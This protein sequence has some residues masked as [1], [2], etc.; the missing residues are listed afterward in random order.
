[1][2]AVVIV[3]VF[4]GVVVAIIEDVVEIVVVGLEQHIKHIVIVE[5]RKKGS[6]ILKNVF[7]IAILLTYY[8]R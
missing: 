8:C 7:F 6:T 3:G 4:A 2:T 1:V 5:S